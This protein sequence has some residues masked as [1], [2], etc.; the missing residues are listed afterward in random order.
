MN[1]DYILDKKILIVDDEEQLLS[2]VSLILRDHNFKHI[3]TAS[4][5]ENSLLLYHE[6][7]P[8]LVLLDI[9]LPDGNGFTLIE[10]FKKNADIPIIFLTAKDTSHD[11]ICGLKLGADDYIIKPFIP[12]E[13]VLRI[14]HILRRCYKDEPS[15]ITLKYASIDLNNAMV[16]KDGQ[17]Y[18]L[19]ATEFI[20]LNAL[21][22]NA[23]KIVG[24]DSLCETVW[25]DNPFGYERSLQTHIG[26]IRGKIE[27]TPSK[28]ESLITIKGLGYKLLIPKK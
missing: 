28:P 9:M 7:K 14:M 17:E 11:K 27:H 22:R 25:G 24:V 6:I 8:D 26:R 23:N 13:L 3:Y 12:D 4:T 19:T 2:M 20:L 21:I 16:Y 10:E 15:V 5:A 18:Q 1:K